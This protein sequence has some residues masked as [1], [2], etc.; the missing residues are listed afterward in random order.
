MFSFFHAGL[1][2]E[3]IPQAVAV[4]LVVM[5]AWFL[6]HEKEWQLLSLEELPKYFR[7]ALA[8]TV[9][10]GLLNLIGN[11]LGLSAFPPSATL[12]FFVFVALET[13]FAAI[14]LQPLTRG[15]LLLTL[16]MGM[17]VVLPV[18][19]VAV[20][21]FAGLVGLAAG[22]LIELGTATFPSNAED[23]VLPGLWL[24]RNLGTA[25]LPV[26]MIAPSD[27]SLVL[28]AL[29]TT[30]FLR[31]VQ[32]PFLKVDHL[33][34]KRLGFALTGATLMYVAIIKGL[35]SQPQALAIVFGAALAGAYWLEE[36]DDTS[37]RLNE[38]NRSL[39]RTAVIAAINISVLL[40]GPSASLTTVYLI[41]GAAMLVAETS[42]TARVMS[43]FCIAQVLFLEFTKDRLLD[44]GL[45]SSLVVS[46]VVPI[47]LSG[48]LVVFFTLTTRSQKYFRVGGIL[49]F[50][51][52]YF[53]GV[54]CSTNIAT[55]AKLIFPIPLIA[56]ALLLALW[57]NVFL[58][59]QAT[60]QGQCMMFIVILLAV[61]NLSI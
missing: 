58:E 36:I 53:L 9:L 54:Y 43:F 1:S 55:V 32:P 22:K 61:A 16:C 28:T 45:L 38:L 30:L 59:K 14:Q 13:L 4:L 44:S 5:L 26:N 49:A 17:N 42:Q 56:I 15:I 57:H 39:K 8:A 46:V 48:A 29:A 12:F 27:N 50:V 11:T 23:I 52:A 20:A 19:Q 41:C 33:F 7:L 18:E 10:F 25:T 24:C 21:T 40:F 47:I 35:S 60:Q 6:F 34:V 3:V 37:K 2:I 31:W 51:I